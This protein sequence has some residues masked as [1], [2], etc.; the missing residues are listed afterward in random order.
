MGKPVRWI[1]ILAVVLFLNAGISRAQSTTKAPSA[2]A[3]TLKPYLVAMYVGNLEDSVK[4][5]QEMLGFNLVRPIM[6]FPAHEVRIA[7]LEL[8]GFRLEL[9]EKKH[10]FPV[11]KKFPEL[12]EAIQG[13][14]K[15]AFSPDDIESLAA[16][17]K[18]KDVTFRYHVTVD[19]QFD[20]KWFIVED[21]DGHWIQFFQPLPNQ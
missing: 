3:T 16:L 10:T 11:R 7:F 19:K 1:A 21:L 6:D 2:P 20:T 5:Y 18:K 14:K 9:V 12:D 17:L 15:L 8:N 13:F 4:W